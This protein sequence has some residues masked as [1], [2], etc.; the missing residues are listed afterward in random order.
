M[1]AAALHHGDGE[2]PRDG[3]GKAT[4][5]VANRDLGDNAADHRPTR[6]LSWQPPTPPARKLSEAVFLVIVVVIFSSRNRYL[7]ITDNTVQGL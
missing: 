2:L 6:H 1:K 7:Y 4:T 5:C 3:T